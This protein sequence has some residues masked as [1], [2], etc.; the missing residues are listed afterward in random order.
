MIHI[1]EGNLIPDPPSGD[2]NG[3][4]LGC[5]AVLF[6][7]GVVSMGIALGLYINVPKFLALFGPVP[8]TPGTDIYILKVAAVPFVIIM[9]AL[10]FFFIASMRKE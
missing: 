1:P 4:C 8:D 2:G 3:S 7:I 9:A 6:G 5:L 10:L